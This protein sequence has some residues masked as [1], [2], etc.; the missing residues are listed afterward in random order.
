MC[1]ALCRASYSEEN[2]KPR[3]VRHP[4]FK[5]G[6]VEG[7]LS[8]Y[9]RGERAVCGHFIQPT[10]IRHWPSRTPEAGSSLHWMYGIRSSLQGHFHRS[11]AEGH[12][13]TSQRRHD[14]ISSRRGRP[15]VGQ[16]V[17]ATNTASNSGRPFGFLTCAYWI[18][19]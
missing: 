1:D 5:S 3:V 2:G 10:Y 13:L 12:I 4:S 19:A 8:M 18:G 15:L 11:S 6:T 14:L 7:L 9:R 16:I 17:N